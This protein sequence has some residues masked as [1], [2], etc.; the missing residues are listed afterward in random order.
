[1][2]SIY[3]N[4]LS[5]IEDFETLINKSFEQC[6]NIIETYTKLGS[7]IGEQFSQAC[8]DRIQTMQNE[9]S[10][11][12][13]S[14][15]TYRLIAAATKSIVSVS[16]QFIGLKKAKKEEER[17]KKSILNNCKNLEQK[18]KTISPNLWKTLNDQIS[19]RKEIVNNEHKEIQNLIFSDKV[20]NR[21]KGKEII[22]NHLYV[23]YKLNFRKQQIKQ[24]NTFFDE[25]EFRLNDLQNF[26]DWLSRKIIINESKYFE[27]VLLHYRHRLFIFY[28]INDYDKNEIDKLWNELSS[29]IPNLE[30]DE[31][32]FFSNVELNENDKKDMFEF[33]ELKDQNGN[34]SSFSVI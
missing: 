5:M 3:D 20:S 13:K 32:D 28:P 10:F 11:H 27:S 22:Q 9:G 24:L 30:I 26:S 21:N 1:M 12:I 23:F 25:I 15:L 4:F 29:S 19:T 14:E 17:I 34:Y 7:D 16:G 31:N 18:F 33:Q 6:N 8:E 2:S